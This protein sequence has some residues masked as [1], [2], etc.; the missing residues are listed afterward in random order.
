MLIAKITT[1][2]ARMVRMAV[3]EVSQTDEALRL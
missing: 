3:M 1:R 2:N